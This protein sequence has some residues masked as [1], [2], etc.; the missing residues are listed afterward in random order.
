MR[1]NPKQFTGEIETFPGYDA[2]FS[3]IPI[4]EKEP[5]LSHLKTLEQSAVSYIFTVLSS[6]SLYSKLKCKS[7]FELI[8]TYYNDL[9]AK[10]KPENKVIIN[11]SSTSTSVALNEINDECE[12]YICLRDV[13]NMNDI[14]SCEIFNLFK[15]NEFYSFNITHFVMLVYL[16]LAFECN[17]IEDYIAFF[18]ESL[19]KDISS[20]ETFITVARMKA[21][22]NVVGISEKD[23]NDVISG[24]NYAMNSEIDYMKFREFYT[25]LGKKLKHDSQQIN[26]QTIFNNINSNNTSNAHAF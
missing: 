11:S 2:I 17:E 5:I 20:S 4:E 19:F 6:K 16:F 7:G 13:F 22:G 1:T 24:L 14:D 23:M 18:G 15:Y 12:L 3:Q 8:K 26:N 9:L 25:K 21:I 10:N